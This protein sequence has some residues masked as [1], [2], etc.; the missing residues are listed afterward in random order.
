MDDFL[1][2]LFVLKITG[3]DSEPLYLEFELE[4]FLVG[5]WNNKS[6]IFYPG[7]KIQYFLSTLPIRDRLQSI[8]QKLLF[9]NFL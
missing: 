7:F 9:I 8:T 1:S 2:Q 6:T 5:S 3:P 4:I